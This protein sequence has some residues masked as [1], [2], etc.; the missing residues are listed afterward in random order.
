MKRSGLTQFSRLYLFWTF[1]I[2]FFFSFLPPVGRW[3]AR[4]G[5]ARHGPARPGSARSYTRNPP[6]GARNL[7]V[8]TGSRRCQASELISIDRIST[9]PISR[10]LWG[11]VSLS[12]SLSLFSFERRLALWKFLSSQSHDAPTRCTNSKKYGEELERGDDD[13][14]GGDTRG[15]CW[16][17]KF[18]R[19]F[20]STRQSSF[21]I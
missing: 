10:N 3:L 17:G 9:A 16:K 4:L 13:S 19:R 1:R 2:T 7:A 12:L 15:V 6:L 18:G 5:S 20:H 11:P 21:E 14:R 8:S